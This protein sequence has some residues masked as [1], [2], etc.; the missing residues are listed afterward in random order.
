MK[1]R[2]MAKMKNRSQLLYLM[3]FSAF[4]F[5]IIICCLLFVPVQKYMLD[6]TNVFQKCDG[7]VTAAVVT[8]L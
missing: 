5:S 1:V 6:V 2:K 3:I 4:S 7:W 8:E